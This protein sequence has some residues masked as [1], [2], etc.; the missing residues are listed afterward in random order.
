M[1]DSTKITKEYIITGGTHVIRDASGKRFRK[2]RGD[3]ITLTDQEAETIKHKVRPVNFQ[4]EG[5]AKSD[6][7]R[8]PVA[9]VLDGAGEVTGVAS[10]ANGPDPVVTRGAIGGHGS[11][12]N[13]GAGNA[14][15]ASLDESSA[16]ILKESPDVIPDLVEGLDLETLGALYDAEFGGQKRPAVLKAIADQVQEQGGEIETPEEPPAE[17]SSKTTK[18]TTRKSSISTKSA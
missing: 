3:R 13:A 11:S 18:T 6:D 8:T 9:G 10:T 1:A 15:S 14:Q 12:S 5:K 2:M 17:S 7:G 4:D 16:A